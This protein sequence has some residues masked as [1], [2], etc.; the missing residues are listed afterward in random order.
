MARKGVAKFRGLRPSARTWPPGPTFPARVLLNLP[1]R[2]ALS[3]FLGVSG[4][5]G[6]LIQF[7]WAPDPGLD[8]AP[9]AL[10]QP[11]G[12]RSTQGSWTGPVAPDQACRMWKLVTA[13]C[14]AN[15]ITIYVTGY[16]TNYLT[17]LDT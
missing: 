4:P 8:Q 15:F 9:E 1:Q 3:P 17:T 7:F 2:L 10:D 5:R 13:S 6:V 16:L 14:Q 11:C 12:P